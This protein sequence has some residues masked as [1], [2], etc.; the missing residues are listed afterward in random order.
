MDYGVYVLRCAQ[1]GQLSIPAYYVG[2]AFL[3]ELFDRLC[4]HFDQH[5]DSA[6]FTKQNK[7]QGVEFLWPARNRSAE[8]Y[9][10][11]F[12]LEKYN[13]EEDVLRH[14]LVG[15]WTQTG[16]KPLGASDYNRLQREYRMVKGR[17]LECG[18][19]GHYARHCPNVL[20]KTSA[21][22]SSSGA[23]EDLRAV[24]AAP[25]PKAAKIALPVIDAGA[26]PLVATPSEPKAAPRA[27]A[28]DWE[29]RAEAWLESKQDLVFD[30]G[31]WTAFKPVL[32]ALNLPWKNPNRYLQ[33]ESDSP[34][35]IWILGRRQPQTGRDF[36]RGNKKHGGNSPFFVRRAFLK[37]VL[38]ARYRH[39][40]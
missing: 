8:A 16:A 9:L 12:L 31:G 19:G 21:A 25:K 7:P 38:V 22:K 2:I 23:D 17:C 15:G 6:V 34:Q 10:Y 13:K 14:V 26:A 27:V 40:I 5:D 39:K 18:R 20:V 33:A 11:Y 24:A 30:N 1:P 29:Q 3:D 28:V 4:K 35:S 37:R 32:R 36:K